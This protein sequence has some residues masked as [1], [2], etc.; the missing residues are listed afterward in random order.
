MTN[1]RKLKV[2]YV[3]TSTG[4][5]LYAD[6]NLL[7]IWSLR[8]SNPS[9]I[10]FLLCDADTA[11][12]LQ[13]Y[14]HP[15]LQNVDHSISVQTPP[16]SETFRN[17]YVKTSMRSYIEGAF[18]YLDADTL[19]RGRLS[20]IFSTDA[21]FCAAPNHS[22]TGSPSEIPPEERKLF[23]K[24]KWQFPSDFYVN[25]GVLFFADNPTV[26]EFFHIWHRKWLQFVL[27]T[28]EHFD[29]PSLNSALSESN[30]QFS[31]L[32]HRF[33]A[34]IQNCPRTALGAIVWHFYSSQRQYPATVFDA[35]LSKIS[36]EKPSSGLWV[37]DLCEKTH[38]WIVSNLSEWFYV[39]GNTLEGHIPLLPFI[40]YRKL[41]CAADLL[42]RYLFSLK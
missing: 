29:Q 13:Q 33:N 35:A 18:L 31:L 11:S 39:K 30:V 9:A 28:G 3:L 4:R 22:G 7:S 20:P 16:G 24:M 5:D 1:Q 27:I 23:E 34:Q 25:G 15:I 12:V 32:P 2:C 8:L 37:R 36:K 42:T 10:I 19:I 26:Y 14:R 21:S 38:P 41:L 40:P 17:R 6:M